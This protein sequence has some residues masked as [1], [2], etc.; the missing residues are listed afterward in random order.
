MPTC[1]KEIVLVTTIL[2]S[3]FGVVDA[4]LIVHTDPVGVMDLTSR[5]EREY[6]CCEA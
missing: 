6:P 3:R 1:E 4:A 2:V 5:V